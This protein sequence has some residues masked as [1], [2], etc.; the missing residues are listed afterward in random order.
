MKLFY[1]PASPYVRKVMVCAIERGLDGRIEKVPAMANPV[2]QNADIKAHNPSGK[3]PTM[4]T[5]DGTALFDSRVICEY[6]DALGRAKRL[7]PTKGAARW[8]AITLQALADGL[9]D[10][11]LLARYEA[12]VRPE[13]RRWPDWSA[14]QMRKIEDSLDLLERGWIRHLKGD[15][16]IGVVAT[17][18]ALG[19][20]DFRFGA[21]DWR[22][23]RP[24]LAAWFEK[25]GKRKSM[26]A[27][28]PVG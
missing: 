18:C 22:A 28:M 8:S 19:Y 4:V 26:K 1:S 6:L 14:G 20:L 7:F 9:L 13:D 2:N 16:D 11:A 27:T 3:V 15:L 23:T 10:A 12:T 24:K 21:H 25:F 17:G 5:D